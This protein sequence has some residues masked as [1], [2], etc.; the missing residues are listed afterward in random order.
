MLDA[1]AG[2][3]PFGLVVVDGDVLLFVAGVLN[4]LEDGVD[5]GVVRHGG[6]NVLNPGLGVRGIFSEGVHKIVVHEGA[7]QWGDTHR[8]NEGHRAGLEVN[9]VQ[10]G[11]PLGTL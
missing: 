10:G 4:A 3:I 1:G 2:G 8:V 11:L 6:P 7:F 5:V 9:G